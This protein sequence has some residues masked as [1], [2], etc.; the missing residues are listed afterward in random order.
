MIPVASAWIS[1][2]A[3]RCTIETKVSETRRSFEREKI[4]FLVRIDKVQKLVEKLECQLKNLIKRIDSAPDSVRKPLNKKV[5]ELN[6]DLHF[7]EG[8]RRQAW[9]LWDETYEMSQGGFAHHMHQFLKLIEDDEDFARQASQRLT[10][11]E[12][13][14]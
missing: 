7:L 2:K 5:A 11:V 8:C 13:V 14:L 3:H 10:L 4:E 9:S 6:S 12:D 1:F